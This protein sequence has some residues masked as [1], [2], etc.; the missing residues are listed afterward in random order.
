MNQFLIATHS[1]LAEGL[2]HAVHFFNSEATNV[3]Y[4]NEPQQVEIYLNRAMRYT[5]NDKNRKSLMAMI[6]DPSELD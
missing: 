1:T 5:N 4:L 3:H 2:V 6:S